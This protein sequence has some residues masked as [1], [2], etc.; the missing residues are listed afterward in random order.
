[1]LLVFAGVLLYSA[2][3]LLTEGDEE[4]EEDL[5]QNP[6]VKLTTRYLPSTDQYDGD[7]FFTTPPGA[8]TA[9]ATP[10]LL[11][12]VSAL[13]SLPPRAHPLLL[14]LVSAPPLERVRWPLSS[15]PSS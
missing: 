7:N 10:L 2:Y 15:R 8:D 12:L 5:S 6:I 4:E 3:G 11:A 9:L 14:A 13:P 1:M